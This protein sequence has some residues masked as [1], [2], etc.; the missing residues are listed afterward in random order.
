MSYR[1]CDQVSFCV[2]GGRAVFLDARRDR[3]F[4]LGSAAEFAFRDLLDQEPVGG[5]GL[6]DLIRSGLVEGAEDSGSP[7][8]PVSVSSP[9][10]SLLEQSSVVANLG[11]SAVIEAA[12]DLVRARSRLKRRAFATLLDQ[13]RARRHHLQAAP[14]SLSGALASLAASYNAARRM[15]PVK[16]VCLPDSLALLDFLARRQLS[17]DL[18]FG[19]KLNPFAAHCWV[20][21]GDVALNEA[22]DHVTLYTPILVV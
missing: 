10:Q 14:T 16:P 6:D 21:A 12:C 2:T 9:S 20:Q 17:A 8:H 4:C 19:V 22:S 18:V 3:Y 15:V 13:L 7:I 11:A 1:L 5:K